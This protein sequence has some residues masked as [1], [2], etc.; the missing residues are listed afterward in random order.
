MR[1][2][3]LGGRANSAVSRNINVTFR[4][5]IYAYRPSTRGGKDSSRGKRSANTR[6][7]FQQSKVS[8]NAVRTLVAFGSDPTYR[9]G[10]RPRCE[11][12][13]SQR[14]RQTAA[15]RDSSA[16]SD[17]FKVEWLRNTRRRGLA[18]YL[19]TYLLPLW[20]VVSRLN[21]RCGGSRLDTWLVVNLNGVLR[22]LKQKD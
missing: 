8:T 14:S 2:S 11:I 17:A 21:P 19:L 18:N 15:G 6:S 10:R 12:S 13:P 9:R 5:R 20:R 7:I 1:S 4:T 22:G 3:G 16:N